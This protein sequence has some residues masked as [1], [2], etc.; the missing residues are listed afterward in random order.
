MSSEVGRKE[1]RWDVAGVGRAC[2]DYAVLVETYPESDTK[3][4]ALDRFEGPGSPVPNALAQ[5]AVWRRRTILS[6]VVG[7]DSQGRE[8]ITANKNLGINCDP[9]IIRPQERT[10][11]AFLWVEQKTGKR[12]VVLDRNIASLSPD[13]VPYNELKSCAFLLIDGWEAEAN[14]EAARTVGEHGGKVMM[15]AGAVR[16]RMEEQLRATDILIGPVSFSRGLFGKMDLFQAVRRLRDYGSELVIIT[17][18]AAGC[19]AGWEDQVQ[20]LPAFKIDALDT[21]G[22]GDLFHAGVL[23]GLLEGWEVERCVRWASATAALGS[24]RLGG[25]G[26]LPSVEEVEGFLEGQ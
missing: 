8:V 11:R 15:D 14:L 2:Y 1:T 26:R 23:H 6:A 17:N 5:L 22:A 10:P 4:V 19:V 13:D 12:T 7:D 16:P 3:H 18:G 20:W 21:T 24:T 25:R 9:I